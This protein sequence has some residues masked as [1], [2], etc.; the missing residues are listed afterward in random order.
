MSDFATSAA[1]LQTDWNHPVIPAQVGN[2][3]GKGY[4]DG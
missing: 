2:P 4:L 1:K 3:R